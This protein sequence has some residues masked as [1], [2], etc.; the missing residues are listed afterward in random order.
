MAKENTSTMESAKE[1]KSSAN[2][3]SAAQPQPGS[4]RRMWGRIAFIA[5]WVSGSGESAGWMSCRTSGSPLNSGLFF[6]G[7]RSTM[8]ITHTSESSSAKALQL[9]IPASMSKID[10]QTQ[11]WSKSS[12][13]VRKFVE[14]AGQR[15]EFGEKRASGPMRRYHQPGEMAVDT[16]LPLVQDMAQLTRVAAIGGLASS[17]NRAR[18]I[19][20]GHGTAGNAAHQST[21]RQ[22]AG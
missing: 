4:G 15:L 16:L 14:R 9:K 3:G 8:R 7:I 19:E 18:W 2:P 1:T 5:C 12:E 17:R 21:P 22:A 6:G 10:Y 11:T 20:P 13:D